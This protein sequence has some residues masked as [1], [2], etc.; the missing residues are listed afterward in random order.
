MRSSIDL[1]PNRL[2][3]RLHAVLPRSSPAVV[4]FIFRFGLI[5]L[6]LNAFSHSRL[7]T[8]NC[9]FCYNKD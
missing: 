8:Y 7:D 3:H 9:M 6:L 4:R 1:E 5:G 2:Y